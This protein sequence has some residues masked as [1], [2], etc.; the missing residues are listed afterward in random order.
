MAGILGNGGMGQ[1]GILGNMSGQSP[2]GPPVPYAQ[3]PI[4]TMLGASL[5]AGRTPQQGFQNFAQMLPSAMQA[6]VQMQQQTVANQDKEQQAA[7]AEARRN[8][9][10]DVIKNWSGIPD[11][12]R[13]YYLANPDQFG[14]YVKTQMQG[15]AG[16]DEFGLTGIPGVDA[17]GNP[18][19]LQLGKNGIAT[20]AKMP[21]GVTISKEPIKLDAGTH[22][23]LLDP[24]TRQPVG[25]IAKDVAG[26][27]SA[28][29]QGT[30]QGEAAANLPL[31]EASADRMVRAIDD[32]LNDPALSRVTGPLQSLLPNITG[33]ANR[34]QSKLDQILGGTFLQAYNDLR[35]G[36]QITEKEGEKAT[37]AYNRLTSTGM[38]DQDYR[39]ALVEFRT[40]VLKLVEVARRKASAPGQV[41]PIPASEYFNQ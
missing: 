23:V 4:V 6:K 28:E 5:L 40:E 39:E 34:A 33:E 36:G 37:A 12:M 3:N 21:E 24:I 31:V 19:L 7:A 17:E 22:Y 13:A 29:A 26:Q 20:Q 14:D 32:A 41:A 15:G 10:N 11:Q 38:N 27:Q 1:P 8:Q 25:Q 9:M 30:R 35:G 16:A 18:V 2:F